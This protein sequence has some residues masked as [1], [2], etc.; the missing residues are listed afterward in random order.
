ME[1]I[2][3]E[4]KLKEIGPDEIRNQ[5]GVLVA[6]PKTRRRLGLGACR[7]ER[8]RIAD[9]TGVANL[10][11][12]IVQRGLLRRREARRVGINRCQLQRWLTISRRQLQRR[13]RNEGRG[14]CAESWGRGVALRS[15]R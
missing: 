7:Y 10:L 12:C 4:W 13:M 1:V 15:L 6:A 14:G 2:R 3:G 5:W 9:E 11:R 8:A